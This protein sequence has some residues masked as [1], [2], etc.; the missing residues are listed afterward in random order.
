MRFIDMENW[1]RKKHYSYFREL[2]YPHFGICGYVDVTELQ[3]RVKSRGESFFLAFMYTAV[4]AANEIEELRYRIREESVLVHDRVNPSFTVMSDEEV[5]SFCTASFYDS[6]KEFC[7]CASREIELAKRNVDIEDEPGRDDLLYITCIPW[8]S[9]TGITHPV[10][11]SPV[12]SIP[13]ISW[14]KYFEENGR[15]KLPLSVQAHH[16]LVDGAHVGR[17][18]VR[19]QEILDGPDRYL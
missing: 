11:M 12:D 10:H 4:K 6:Y 1:K 18:F 14:G 3:K 19:L 9:F 7:L 8:I 16:A 2:D 15:V 5:F 17:Y 13:R